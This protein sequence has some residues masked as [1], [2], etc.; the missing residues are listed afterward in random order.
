MANDHAQD[1]DP[2]EAK[3]PSESTAMMPGKNGGRLRRGG[4]NKGGPGRPPNK[5][6]SACL[7]SFDQRRKVLEQI[8]DD[9]KERAADRIAAVKALGQFGMPQQHEHSGPDGGPIPLQDLTKLSDDELK[10]R[11]AALLGQR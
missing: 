10:A 4:T 5:V 11:A 2:T 3:T 6:R 7:H 1:T 8:A 9:A